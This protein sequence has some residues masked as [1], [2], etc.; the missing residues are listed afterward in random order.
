MYI[1]FNMEK[2]MKDKKTFCCKE[3]KSTDLLFQGWV[4]EFNK[5]IESMDSNVIWCNGCNQL[6][7]IKDIND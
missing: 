4:D 5:Y 3:C 6:T 1:N 7:T 2:E